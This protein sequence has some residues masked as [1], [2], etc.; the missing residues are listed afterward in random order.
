MKPEIQ[1][2][3]RPYYLVLGRFS[4]GFS[5]DSEAGRRWNRAESVR[6]PLS[7]LEQPTAMPGN[8]FP[9][10]EAAFISTCRQLIPVNEDSVLFSRPNLNG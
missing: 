8:E 10:T 4:V 3:V 7:N 1:E 9:I 5:R 2:T 6:V